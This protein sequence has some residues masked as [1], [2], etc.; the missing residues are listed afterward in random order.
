MALKNG[1]ELPQVA[2]IQLFPTDDQVDMPDYIKT[3][4]N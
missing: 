1:L 3:Q 2:K 4:N